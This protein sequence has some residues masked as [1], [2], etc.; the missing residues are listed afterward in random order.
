MLKTLG[1]KS[2]LSEANKNKWKPL[3]QPWFSTEEQV[4]TS[5]IPESRL[6]YMLFYCVHKPCAL[7]SA[8]W[9]G[10]CLFGL[11]QVLENIYGN[12]AW[13]KVGRKSTSGTLP[14]R[15]QIKCTHVW[16]KSPCFHLLLCVQSK[17]TMLQSFCFHNAK[18]KHNLLTHT[19]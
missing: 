10:W 11:S 2:G 17:E 15:V 3:D 6:K 12:F 16:A 18:H 4:W 13:A 1:F 5:A 9:L 8:G 7:F 19:L 14:K